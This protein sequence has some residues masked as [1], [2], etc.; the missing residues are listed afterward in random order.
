MSKVKLIFVGEGG[1]GKTCLISQ[2]MENKFTE[3][4]AM[5]VGR[6]KSLKEI[7]INGKTIN[8]EIW[9]TPGQEKF[10]SASKMFMK[11][12][13]IALIVYSIID[14]NSFE[15]LDKWIKIVNEVNKNEEVIFGIA[16]NKSDMFEKQEVS[17]EDGER[18]VKDKNILFFET[19]AKDYVSIEKAFIELSKAYLKMI[20]EKNKNNPQLEMN[21]NVDENDI[22]KDPLENNY[23]KF[24][25][26]NSKDDGKDCS[27]KCSII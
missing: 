26:I 16:A 1:V 25:D 8:L 9:D 7:E 14:K 19:S 20:E 3:E 18:Y 6:D 4:H 23:V 27:S 5:T 11:N 15:K 24:N 21:Q 13:K 17:K 2:Y 12:T 10:N 22:K